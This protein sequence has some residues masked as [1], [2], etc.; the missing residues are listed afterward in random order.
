MKKSNPHRKCTDLPRYVSAFL[1]GP[2]VYGVIAFLTNVAEY[3][4]DSSKYIH[5]GM[6]SSDVLDTCLSIQLKE[7]ATI[8]LKDLKQLLKALKI[9]SLKYKSMI[10]IGRSHG[11]HAEPITFGLKLASFYEEFKNQYELRA[12]DIDLNEDWLHYLD[13]RNYDLYSKEVEDFCA[14]FLKEIA[15]TCSFSKVVLGR[16]VR[17]LLDDL[18][19]S[20]I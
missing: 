8:L 7:S 18:F 15:A 5:N 9:K 1:I 6:T 14:A 10:T 16:L 13:F 12:S 3:V 20:A 19:L 11:I 2:M 4:G 17:T